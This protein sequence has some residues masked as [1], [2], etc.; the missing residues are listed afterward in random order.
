MMELTANQCGNLGNIYFFRGELDEA[1]EMYEKVLEI[2]E[3]LGRPDSI[4]NAY[5]NLG[6]VY[7]ERGD[8]KKAKEYWEKALALFKKIGMPREVEKMEGWIE[9]I[10]K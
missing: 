10:D 7:Q 4:A 9:T 3:R 5:G 2:E 6:L 1:E 8:N